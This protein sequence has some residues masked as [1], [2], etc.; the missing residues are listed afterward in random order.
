MK[1]TDGHLL[2]AGTSEKNN[3]KKITDFQAQIG[4]RAFIRTWTLIR[5]FTFTS[6]KHAYIILTPLNPIFI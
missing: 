1:L 6:R 4:G 5:I 2:E 3:K